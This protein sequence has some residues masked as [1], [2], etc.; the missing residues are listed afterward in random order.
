MTILKA[1]SPFIV[2]LV[3]YVGLY[4]V[5]IGRGATEMI[6]DIVAVCGTAVV[7]VGMVLFLF[8]W[9]SSAPK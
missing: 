4:Q 8:G 3:V 9:K 6:A 1:V 2:G 5:S 7:V